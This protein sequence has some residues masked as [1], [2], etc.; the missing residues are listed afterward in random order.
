MDT[1]S[2]DTGPGPLPN[3]FV[4]SSGLVSLERLSE[5][6]RLALGPCAATG[7]T[8]P[9]AQVIFIAIFSILYT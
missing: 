7:I 2:V 3:I 4:S 9:S 1:L 6:S 8:F 5:M